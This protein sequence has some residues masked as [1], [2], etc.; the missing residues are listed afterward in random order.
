M[1]DALMR[2]AA[3][4]P[5]DAALLDTM[6]LF[7]PS[8]E[9]RKTTSQLALDRAATK[10]TEREQ[11]I[12]DLLD[13]HGPLPLFRLAELLGVADHTISGRLT[14][15]KQKGAIQP[16]GERAIKPITGSKCDVYRRVE[17]P[18]V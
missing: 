16:T 6:P 10:F 8:R 1:S 9:E 12:L 13:R 2:P 5:A 18:A 14:S 17:R 15:L 3:K 4:S 11:Q 7:A